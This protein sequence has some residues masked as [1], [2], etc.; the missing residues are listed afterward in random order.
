[1]NGKKIATIAVLVFFLAFTALSA[2]M[3]LAGPKQD[4]SAEII[5]QCEAAGGI[6]DQEV[7]ECFENPEN[8]VSAEEEC[9]EIGG[10][11]YPE[12]EVCVE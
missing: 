3:Y 1:M 9:N 6:R 5:A 2:V 12:N 8:M 4:N 7:Q 11:R 10:T